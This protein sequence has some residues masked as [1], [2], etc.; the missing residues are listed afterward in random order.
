M[1]ALFGLKIDVVHQALQPH[2]NLE[3]C[4][5]VTVSAKTN[6]IVLVADLKNTCE[7]P[8]TPTNA[9]SYSLLPVKV[10]P[11]SSKELAMCSMAVLH[12]GERL[13]PR[14]PTWDHIVTKFCAHCCLGSS[15]HENGHYIPS[16]KPLSPPN[17]QAP[18]ML[19]TLHLC[20]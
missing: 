10:F 15:A 1:G 14:E 3:I 20:A 18:K 6:C 8:N 12:M 2:P 13:N 19:S 7:P 11:K 4:G 5:Q 17:Q 16:S 9:F